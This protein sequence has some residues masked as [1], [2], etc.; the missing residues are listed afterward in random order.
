VTEVA[1]SDPGAPPRPD[2]SPRTLWSVA[3][4]SIVSFLDE[5]PFQIAAALSFYTLLSLSPLV[6]L[7]V[8]VTGLVWSEHGVREHLVGEIRDL[9]GPA[10]AETV[11]TVLAHASDP[12]QSVT[13]VLV[14]IATLLIGATT[15]FGQ[16][17]AALNQIWNVKAA[18]GRA[19]WSLIRTRLLSL[20]LVLVLGFLLLVS[21]LISAAL[22]ALHAYLSHALPAGGV[23]WQTVNLLVTLGVVTLLIAMIFKVLPDVRVTWSYVWFGAVVT[24]ALFGVGRFVIGFYLGR[25]SI[26]S[27]YGAAGSLVVFLVWV[28]YSSLIL[29]FG[30]KLTQVYARWHGA[31]FGPAPHAVN[32]GR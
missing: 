10:G 20:A 18:P 30:A 25:A 15:V 22:A 14:G 16:L 1:G 9:V 23:I 7:V 29:L 5:S 12:G 21:L 13:S 26:A 3:R 27:S 17:Q 24:S 28:Y 2:A 19:F 32:A 31:D 11:K 8:G 6:L 4:E